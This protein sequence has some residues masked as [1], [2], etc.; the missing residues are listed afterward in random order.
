[1]KKVGYTRLK[2]PWTYEYAPVAGGRQVTRAYLWMRAEKG[3]ARALLYD[4]VAVL[5]G[6]AENAFKAR[7]VGGKSLGRYPSLRKAKLACE[8][9]AKRV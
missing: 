2:F 8:A 3:T 4:C 1:M 9:D 5:L 6:G 7:V